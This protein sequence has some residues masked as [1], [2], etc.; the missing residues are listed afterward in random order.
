MI[1]DIPFTPHPLVR[2][3]STLI[4]KENL[5]NWEIDFRELKFEK[6]L[7]AGAFGVVFQ[8]KW[9]NGSCAVKQLSLDGKDS[10]ALK[11][12]LKEANNMKKIRRKKKNKLFFS[13][14]NLIYISKKK[15]KAHANVVGLL[16]VAANPDFPLCIV[17]EYLPQGSLDHLLG[18]PSFFMDAA[19]ATNMLLIL[20]VE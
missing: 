10:K 17:T 1:D 12:F 11:D 6:K 19:I 16:G 18:D 14:K 20:Q 9:R 4:L 5:G 3:E 7:G 2:T 8:A 13:F 15:K